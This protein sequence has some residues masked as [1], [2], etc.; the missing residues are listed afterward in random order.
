M[1]KKFKLWDDHEYIAEDCVFKVLV[2]PELPSGFYSRTIS[3][4]PQ[5]ELFQWLHVP[6]VV[7][8]DDQ[9]WTLWLLDNGCHDRPTMHGSSME[10]SEVIKYLLEQKILG[11]K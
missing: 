11:Y 6:Y 3:K 7:G 10:F 1:M 8:N 5:A 2:N 4:R 9:G